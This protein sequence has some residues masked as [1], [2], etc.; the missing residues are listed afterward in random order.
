MAGTGGAVEVLAEAA[1]AHIDLK[2]VRIHGLDVRRPEQGAAFLLEHP[3]V[4][5]L[6]ARIG[7]EILVRPRTGSD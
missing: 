7:R 4:A 3:G 6:A 5:R 1:G 2:A